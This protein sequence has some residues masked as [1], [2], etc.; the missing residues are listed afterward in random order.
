MAH[1]SGDNS[2]LIK[3]VRRLKGQLEG[4]ERLLEEHA[5]CYKVLQSAAACRGA[6]DGLTKELILNHLEHHLIKN[7]DATDSVKEA[8][9]EMHEI[10]KSY[11]K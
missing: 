2:K 9:E 10:I 4:V 8:S 6:L 7:P 1:L 11:M 3:R 5:D